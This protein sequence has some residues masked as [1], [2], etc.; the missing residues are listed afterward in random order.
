MNC[1]DKLRGNEQDIAHGLDTFLRETV[2]MHLLSDVRI[3]TFLSGGI[4]SGTISAITAELTDEP[5]P[6]FSIGVKEQS[7]NE[8][9]YARMVA[10]RYGMEAHERVVSADV[11][12]HLPAMIH[13]PDEPAD[14][15]GVGFYLVGNA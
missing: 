8:L 13:H 6:C 11:L 5:V 14:P 2:E 15:L 4:D 10:Q 3:G 7:F 9:P 12:Y 1:G